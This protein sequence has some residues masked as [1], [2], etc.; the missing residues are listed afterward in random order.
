MEALGLDVRLLVAQLINFGLLV[1]LLNKFLYK[2]L[3]KMLDDRKKKIAEAAENNTKIETQLA[4]LKVQEAK[5]LKDAKDKVS[6]ERKIILSSVETERQKI[7]AEAKASAGREVA[8]AGETI[9]GLESEAEKN[10]SHK[11]I[12]DLAD[13]V[14]KKLTTQKGSLLDDLLKNE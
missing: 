2:P 11:V 6:E 8:K 9:K 4:E 12:T 5:V 14:T 10:I 13:Q 7:L 3:I 1:F